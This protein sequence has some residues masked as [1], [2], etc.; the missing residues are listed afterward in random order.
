MVEYNVYREG[1]LARFQTGDKGLTVCFAV[2]NPNTGK[3][4]REHNFTLIWSE[5]DLLAYTL[6]EDSLFA[7]H[8]TFTIRT[9]EHYLSISMPKE[10]EEKKRG[11]V[12]RVLSCN[13]YEG[14]EAIS[15][16]LSP[17][18]CYQLNRFC[19][20]AALVCFVF[21]DRQHFED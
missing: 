4:T 1:K 18:E 17:V 7:T 8:P 9:N 14:G 19:D 21:S 5:I 13:L 3:T 10:S 20:R 2:K 11:W 16:A 6:V 12:S 15:M